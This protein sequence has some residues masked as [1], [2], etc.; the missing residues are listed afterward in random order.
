MIKGNLAKC[1]QFICH[2]VC[3]HVH[4]KPNVYIS[5]IPIK[6]IKKL[7]QPGK[8]SVHGMFFT[9]FANTK[10]VSWLLESYIGNSNEDKIID[11]VRRL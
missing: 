1:I 7:C 11:N 10:Q 6:F 4:T 8:K 2:S 3:H 5:F 9:F